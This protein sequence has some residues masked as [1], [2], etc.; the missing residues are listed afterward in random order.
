M[1]ENTGKKK[2][3]VEYSHKDGR[4][5]TVEVTTEISESGAFD[6]GNRKCGL[7]T[8]GDF[9]QPYDLRYIRGEDL[10]MAMLKNYFGEGIVKATEI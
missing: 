7:L 6:Y 10:H 4:R 2:W 9:E 8:V 5:G 1:M 3:R